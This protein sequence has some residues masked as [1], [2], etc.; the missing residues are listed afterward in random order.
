M[1]YPTIE[2]VKALAELLLGLPIMRQAFGQAR[3]L[4]PAS[5]S[6]P[7]VNPPGRLRQCSKLIAKR[8]LHLQPVSVTTITGGWGVP[9]P[10]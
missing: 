4:P 8:R 5:S 6:A 1:E 7:R 2:Q 9:L 3:R 10:D